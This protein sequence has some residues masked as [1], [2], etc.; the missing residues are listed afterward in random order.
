MSA[1][2]QPK[3]HAARLGRL[4]RVEKSGTTAD[5]DVREEARARAILRPWTLPEDAERKAALT[6][7]DFAVLGGWG[8]AEARR[9]LDMLGIGG[10]S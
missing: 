4:D 1:K 6:V 2:W 7:A 3:D 5:S 9:L 8:V 10:A